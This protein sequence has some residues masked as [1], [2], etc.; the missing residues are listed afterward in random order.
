MRVMMDL[1]VLEVEC[2]S[3]GM[4]GREQRSLGKIQHWWESINLLLGW[5]TFY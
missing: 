4:D 2:L 1:A 5:V 3:M